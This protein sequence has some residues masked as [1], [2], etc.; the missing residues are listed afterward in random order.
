MNGLVDERPA[1][2]ARPTAFDGAA[3]VFRRTIPLDVGVRLNDFSQPSTSNSLLEEL[4]GV[5]KAMLADDAEL[6][7][8]AVCG[9][10]HFARC[11]EVGGD[12][13]FNQHMLF[14]F[15]AE[16]YRGQAKTWQGADVDEID[17]RMTD[18]FFIVRNKLRSGGVGEGA[19]LLRRGVGADRQFVADVSIGL[20]VLVRHCAGADDAYSQR[21]FLSRQ[22]R[23]LSKPLIEM[24]RDKCVIVQMRI[25]AIHAIDL[26]ALA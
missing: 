16:L 9:L 19:T 1:A 18:E 25:G 21:S 10:H 15:R 3:V 7:A 11:L 14:Q 8:R 22:V 17:A 4:C 12:G 13:L 2:F 26:F 6:D 24:L 20:R 23:W 5:V